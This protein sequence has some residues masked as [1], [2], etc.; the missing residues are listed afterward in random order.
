[1]GAKF[2]KVNDIIVHSHNNNAPNPKFHNIIRPI[3]KYFK[4]TR[5]A[6]SLSAGKWM[7]GNSSF[8][9]IKNG[10]ES[11]KYIFNSAHRLDKRNE[12]KISEKD[13]LICHIGRF[14]YQKN[15]KFILSVFKEVLS[16]DDNYKLLLIGKG[17]LENEIR[18]LSSSLGLC[19]KVI[20]AGTRDDIPK[21]L[22]ASDV[23]FFPSLFEGLGI[24]MIEAQANN[25]PIVCSDVIPNEAILSNDVSQLSLTENSVTDWANA[26]IKQANTKRNSNGLLLVRQSGFDIFNSIKEITSLYKNV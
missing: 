21:I 18:E 14:N 11:D 7:F 5:L 19:D 26:L 1:M 10:I 3:L 8:K 17:E 20:F 9:V 16:I 4:L 24:V 2:G 15:H 13:K 6:C 22:S 12:F 23:F 25:L